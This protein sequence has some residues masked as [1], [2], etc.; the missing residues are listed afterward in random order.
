MT[1]FKVL[2]LGENFLINLDGEDQRLGFYTTAFVE[3]SN[4][5][6][7]EE[8]AIELLRDDQEFKRGVL[9]EKSDPPMMFVEDITELESFDG[10]NLPR[11]GFAF[12]RTDHK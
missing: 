7:A 3:A 11:T 2:I 6:H 1:K 12:F 5:E 9:N 10:L 8:L 4:P